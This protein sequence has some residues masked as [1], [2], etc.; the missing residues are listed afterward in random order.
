[1]NRKIVALIAAAVLLVALGGV[2]VYA[3]RARGRAEIVAGPLLQVREDGGLRVVWRTAGPSRYLLRVEYAAGEA[4]PTRPE[5]VEPAFVGGQFVADMPDGDGAAAGRYWL[6]AQLPLFPKRWGP[7]SLDLPGSEGRFRFAV[8][9]DSG[10]GSRA[11][12]LVAKQVVRAQ[13]QLVIHTGDLVYYDG[14]WGDYP[15]KFYEPYA[16]LIGSVPFMP[17]VGNHDLR[18]ADGAPFRRAFALPQNGPDLPYP[19]HTY[20]FDYGDARFVAIDTNASAETLAEKVAPWLGGV[21][22]DCRRRWKFV[23][24]H[25]PPYTGCEKRGPNRKVQRAL[26]PVFESAGVD[27]VFAGHN[28][29]YER[30][31]PLLRG[32]IVP[33]GQGV[34]YVV[35][36]AG[37][38]SRY[39]ESETPPAYIAAYEDRLF[40]FTLV[41][42]EGSTLR[43]RQISDAG[44]VIDEWAWTKPSREPIAADDR[45]PAATGP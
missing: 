43:L 4:G 26:V 27:I 2:C 1:M 3:L 14:A 19:E 37:G 38:A 11:Q 34:V 12:L 30:T 7:W 21:L 25:H 41:M 44:K 33:A 31:H 32:R 5:A 29:L 39:A 8:F 28:H 10:T 13:P 40:S 42:L 18:T 17:V 15:S 6:E 23:Y 20:W 45:Q 24:L 36:G 9:G 16:A 35:T 22:A